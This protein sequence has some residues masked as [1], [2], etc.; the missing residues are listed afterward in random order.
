MVT[1]RSDWAGQDLCQLLENS[2]TAQKGN[3]SSEVE[4]VKRRRRKRCSDQ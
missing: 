4:I 3:R 1:S 2:E